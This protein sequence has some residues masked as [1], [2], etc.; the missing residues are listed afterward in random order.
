MREL[1]PI[2][3]IFLHHGIATAF[4]AQFPECR[5]D[6][7]GRPGER[8]ETPAI[9]FELDGFERLTDIG[10]DQLEV[11][12]QFSA[13]V[14]ESY[15]RRGLLDVRILALAVAQF[16]HGNR[17]GHPV[18]PGHVTSAAPTEFSG[19]MDAYE[20]WRIEWTQSALLGENIWEESGGRDIQPFVS[21]APRIGVPHKADYVPI[22]GEVSV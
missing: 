8:I 2:N 11:Q 1:P 21:W 20:S 12:L 13:T 10:T 17:W 16:V 3:I 6:F 19:P 7:Y 15:K 9:Y 18:S 14:I 5:V 4:K 22:G